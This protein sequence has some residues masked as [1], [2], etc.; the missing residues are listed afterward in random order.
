VQAHSDVGHAGAVEIIAEVWR[1]ALSV[2]PGCGGG[3]AVF[4][5]TWYLSP[6]AQSAVAYLI[7]WV[8]LI[9]AP[10][11]V[12]ELMAQRRRGQAGRSDA[13]QLAR[14]TP[15]PGGPWALFFLL[16]NLVGLTVGAALLLPDLATAAQD[17]IRALTDR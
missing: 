16:A 2:Q 11:P 13:D 10:K 4:W 1:R 15:I 17:A 7:T 5:V 12:L 3:A 9:A 8:L 14:L 6:P